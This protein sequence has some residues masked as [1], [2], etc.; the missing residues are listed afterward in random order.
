MRKQPLIV[1]FGII[2]AVMVALLWWRV[3]KL[4]QTVNTLRVL[5]AAST[6]VGL[7]QRD[8]EDNAEKKQVFKLID[9][10]P[11]DPGKSKVG[12]PWDVERAMMGGAD[13]RAAP[14]SEGGWEWKVQVPLDLNAIPDQHVMPDQTDSK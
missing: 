7:P 3:R 9:S 6:V 12:V 2:L 5:P 8:P 14:A 10:P 1:I 4:E 13:H 11:V